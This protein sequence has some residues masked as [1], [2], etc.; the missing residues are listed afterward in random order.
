VG[1]AAV[2]EAIAGKAFVGADLAVVVSPAPFTRSAIELANVAG[3]RLMHH[4]Q[5]AE[6]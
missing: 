5:L 3:V 4:E 1:N 6:L 2:Q